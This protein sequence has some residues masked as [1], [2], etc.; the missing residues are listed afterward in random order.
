MEKYKAENEI[1]R[2]TSDSLR[3][4]STPNDAEAT[5]APMKFTPNDFIA[6]VVP[7]GHRNGGG[8]GGGYASP[9]HRVVVCQNSGE[10]LLDASTTWDFIQG[11]G[12]FRRGLVDIAVVCDKLKGRVQ[13][14]GQGP[15]FAEG[16][17]RRVIEESAAGGSDELI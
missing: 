3:Q 10:R 14:G 11:H 13:C 15:V 17:V 16:N 9:S 6:K 5:T 7:E 4:S 1:L 2:K 12:L 8:G